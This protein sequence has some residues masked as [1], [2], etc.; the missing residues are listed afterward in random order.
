MGHDAG[1]LRG[2]RVSNLR[3]SFMGSGQAKSLVDRWLKTL[4]FMPNFVFSHAPEMSVLLN[5]VDNVHLKDREIKEDESAKHL[6]LAY[7][8]PVVWQRAPLK[9]F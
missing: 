9:A 2:L 3:E 5:L 4:F 1:E 6:Q 7:C 8:L